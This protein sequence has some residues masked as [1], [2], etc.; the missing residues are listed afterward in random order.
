MN[1]KNFFI[2]FIAVFIFGF[3]WFGKFMHLFHKEAASPVANRGRFWHSFFL[4]GAG[5]DRVRSTA[6]DDENSLGLDCW[7]LDPIPDCGRDLQA[8]LNRGQLDP[9]FRF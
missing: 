5:S 9:N 4:A 7:G 6:A 2:P 1:W 3:L 8:Q